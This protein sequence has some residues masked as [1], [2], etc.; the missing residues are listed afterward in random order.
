M[1]KTGIWIDQRKAKIVDLGPDGPQGFQTL[2][3]DV[4]EFNPTGGAG[5][6]SKGGPQDVVQD[7]KYTERKKHQLKRF[8]SRLAEE[9]AE[10]EELLVLGPGQTGHRLVQEWKKSSPRLANCVVAV[11]TA[12]RMTDNQLKA[13]V[14]DYFG[15]A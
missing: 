6:R 3:S 15:L 5:G 11:E 8:F 9:V 13:W 4:E 2:L 1:K 7:S 14:R 12:D 10:A